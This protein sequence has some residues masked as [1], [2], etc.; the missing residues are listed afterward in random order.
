MGVAA[1]VVG[2]AV[3]VVVVAA[4][5]A[6]VAVENTAGCTLWDLCRQTPKIGT[7]VVVVAA[8]AAA[9]WQSTVELKVQEEGRIQY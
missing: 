7:K 6:I 8:V 2:T 4:V 5:A 9:S 3:A 1:A